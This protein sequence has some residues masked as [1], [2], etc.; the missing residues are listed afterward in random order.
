MAAEE[1]LIN[2][3]KVFMFLLM[4]MF[5][6]S[7]GSAFEFDNVKDYDPITKEVTITNALGLGDV[8]GKAKLLTPL[9]VKVGAGY[10]KVAMF[11]IEAYEDYNDAIKQFVFEDMK[12]KE[13][14]NR[15]IDMKM[16][17]YETIEVNDNEIQ[18][19]QVWSVVNQTNQE[20]CLNVIVGTHE[21]QREV[22]TKVTP[23]DLKKNEKVTIGLFTEVGV[24]DYVDWIPTIYG[25]EIE[26]WATWEQ[27]MN[28]N[29]ESYY[30]AEENSGNLLDST[31]NSYNCTPSGDSPT[32]V[33][34][35]I[36]L[37]QDMD[38]TGDY[39][40]CGDI[41]DTNEF[42]FNFWYNL[43]VANNNYGVI[44]KNVAGASGFRVLEKGTNGIR[45]EY[46]G[47]AAYEC[48]V[49]MD[50]VI[51][52]GA[53]NM[54]TYTRYAN[55]T[56]VAYINGTRTTSVDCLGYVTNDAQ[57]IIGSNSGGT[58]SMNGQLDELGFWTRVLTDAEVTDLYNSNNGLQYV[59]SFDTAPSIT[60]NSPTTNASYITPQNLQF[61][62][63][64]SD[65]INLTD[66]EVYVNDVLNQTNSSGI[67]NTD[68]LFNIPMGDGTYVVYGRATD[69][70]S[71]QTNSSVVE[72]TVDST[73]PSI[74]LT[75]PTGVGGYKKIL[76]NESLNWTIADTNLDSCWY[77]YNGTNN[78]LV[79]NDNQT[80]FL[81]AE[82][83]YSL[84]L[85][86]N[87][88]VGN[89]NSAT[90]SWSYNITEG[91]QTYPTLSIESA[92]EEYIANVNYNSSKFAVINGV[93][94]INNTNY[95]GTRT[96]SGDSAAFTATAT[97]PSVGA[98]TN[99]TAY[100][101]I[102]LTDVSG[103][104][105]YNLTSSNVTVQKI[106]L[107]LCDT[108]NNVS[109]W[110]FSTLDESTNAAIT[111]TFSA[112]FGVKRTGST[113]NNIFTFADLTGT[114]SSFD[115]CISPSSE[116]YTIDTAIEL[117][118]DGYVTK[119]YNYQDVVVTNATREDNLYM[120]ASNLSTSFIVHVTDASG[121]NLEG[122]EVKVQRFYPGLGEWLT[123][124]VLTTDYVGEAVGHFLSEDADYRFLVYKDGIS[125]LNSSATKIVCAVAP[126]TVTL[127]VKLPLDTGYEELGDLSSSIT[128][129][130]T[131]NIFTYTYTDSSGDFD[132]ARL[133]VVRVWPSNS[134]LVIPCDETSTSAVNIMTCDIT[135]Q[136][137]GTY[138][139]TGYIT[140]DGVETPVEVKDGILG[141]RIY[142]S[143]GK[144]GVLWGFFILT[145]IIMLGITRPSL[146]IIFGSIGLV[147]LSLLEIINIGAISIISVLAIAAILLMRVGRE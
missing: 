23:A 94:R 85:Y 104:T 70:I 13:K 84:T 83:E 20:E 111:S 4:G 43:D 102:G 97:M 67:N 129:S 12:K 36:D 30:K 90:T 79:C 21:E 2:M 100:W 59:G 139:A 132:S 55:G 74:S 136:I 69:N 95:L 26:E 138:R 135:G 62:F 122:G 123:T 33:T 45:M 29:I 116:S 134:T 66:V 99:L 42:S 133:Y 128:F 46:Q 53:W 106:N 61:N 68:Y 49:D 11:E 105:N 27:S 113:V 37:G 10:Q 73:L 82:G 65:D 50:G 101:I 107:T 77:N 22:W 34:G 39:F 8:I 35:K 17:S 130:D 15:D 117:S 78:S 114:N 64:A 9:N 98:E 54:I 93:L 92:T 125:L 144:D 118:K 140:R 112:S 87:D 28:V 143:M 108:T 146:A 110:N 51:S 48:D 38:G 7:F 141:D 126:C 103:T 63:M 25:V 137:N 41:M 24:G 32:A 56:S 80:F 16:L 18:C 57:L 119:F 131:T 52:L 76:T 60:L 121:R 142:N 58:A 127:I 44:V 40:S 1:S 19:N 14:V 115:F 120:L 6:I 89:E 124:E 145:G 88:T 109:F 75:S 72:I 147:T 96:G 47:A 91:S 71:Q 5:M 3:K 31:P 86:A 81:Q